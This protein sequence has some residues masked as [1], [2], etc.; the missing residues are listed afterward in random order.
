MGKKRYLMW[1]L[2]VITFL[3][4][5]SF[6]QTSPRNHENK[7]FSIKLKV[8]VKKCSLHI[9]FYDA[10]GKSIIKDVLFLNKVLLNISG[11]A[12]KPIKGGISLSLAKGNYTLIFSKEIRVNNIKWIFDNKVIY[13][14]NSI[15]NCTRLV[16]SRANNVVCL[17]YSPYRLLLKVIGIGSLG[18]YYL[19]NTEAR[20]IVEEINGNTLVWILNYTDL[21]KLALKIVNK[22]YV[23]REFLFEDIFVG[24]VN[25]ET[26]ELVYGPSYQLKATDKTVLRLYYEKKPS[27]SVFLFMFIVIIILLVS[28]SFT[29]YRTLSLEH[30]TRTIMHNIKRITDEVSNSLDKLES[31]T[32]NLSRYMTNIDERIKEIVREQSRVTID[33]IAVDIRET[34]SEWFNLKT[35]YSS[36]E[37]EAMELSS[38]AKEKLKAFE[39][40]YDLAF[41][42]LI[43]EKGMEYLEKAKG[44]TRAGEFREAIINTRIAISLFNLTL[45]MLRSDIVTL[46][47]SKLAKEG[48]Y[49]E[50]PS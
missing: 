12:Y 41:P 29:S 16:I 28:V 48:F 6:F 10:I 32:V 33:E 38:K 30:T 47:L 22:E 11:I 3:T 18:V 37:V 31:F 4:I 44:L 19:N 8:N 17:V 15:L 42:V 35:Q 27:S 43:Y 14:G 25:E 34:L 7:Y 23:K 26:G 2:V 21:A 9:S 36:L 39:R 50:A 1:A 45:L 5:L 13:N 40:E 24:W 20:F 49:Y 46:R